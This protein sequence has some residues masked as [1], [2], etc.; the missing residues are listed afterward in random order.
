[1]ILI[2]LNLELK[3]TDISMYQCITLVCLLMAEKGVIP[4]FQLLQ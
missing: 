4:T 2:P 1:M 3:L